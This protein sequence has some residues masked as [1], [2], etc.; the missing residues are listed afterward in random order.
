M[1]T[2]VI[3]FDELRSE[4]TELVAPTMQLKVVDL[5]SSALVVDIAKN[6]KA[7]QA[8]IEKRRKELVGPLNEMVKKINAAAADVSTPLDNA[9]AYLQVQLSGFA[10]EQLKVQ[11]EARRIADQERRQKEAYLIERIKEEK[12]VESRAAAMFGDDEDE[13]APAPNTV[14]PAD[15]ERAKISQEH[16]QAQYDIAQQGIKNTRK[17]WACK[18]IDIKLVPREF[19]IIQLNEKAVLAAARAGVTEI[20]GVEVFQEVS[21]TIGSRTYVPRI[22][23]EDARE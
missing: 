19:L 23:P 14:S 7:L 2:E 6:V 3:S 9:S 12:A 22:A 17:T 5:K 21:V 8:R 18:L 20:A 15:I 11:E 10:R 4:I 1:S 16:Q 13:P